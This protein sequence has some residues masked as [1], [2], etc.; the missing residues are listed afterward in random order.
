MRPAGSGRFIVRLISASVSRSRYMLSTFA[1]ATMSTVPTSVSST[2]RSGSR[3][4][5]SHRPLAQV[6]TTSVVMRGLASWT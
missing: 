6:N 1:A 4:G 2:V 3:P 5:A